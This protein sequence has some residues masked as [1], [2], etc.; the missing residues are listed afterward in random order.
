MQPS[1]VSRGNAYNLMKT[2]LKEIDESLNKLSFGINHS[3]DIIQ[4]YCSNLQKEIQLVKEQNIKS[5]ENYYDNLPN[6]EASANA[7]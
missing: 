6:T 4:E 7:N 5:I 1:Q 3:M 2:T